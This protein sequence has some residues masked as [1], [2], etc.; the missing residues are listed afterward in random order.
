MIYDEKLLQ[1][2]YFICATIMNN[3]LLRKELCHWTKGMQIRYNLS[4]LEQWT[5]DLNFGP[6]EVSSLRFN[7]YFLLGTYYLCGEKNE[8]IILFRRMPK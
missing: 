1:L 7:E 6:E 5:R 8:L 4:H 3:M 2:F